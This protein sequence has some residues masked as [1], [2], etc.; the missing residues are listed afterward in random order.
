M[1]EYLDSMI[2]LHK[3]VSVSVNEDLCDV[4]GPLFSIYEVFIESYSVFGVLAVDDVGV[5]V[6]WPMN[7]V[8][9]IE[10]VD[11]LVST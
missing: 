6:W 10:S 3:K 11:E 5:R 7:R 2:T 9:R 4:N 1:D 8:I